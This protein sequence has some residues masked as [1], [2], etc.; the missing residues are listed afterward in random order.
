MTGRFLD[1]INLVVLDK[2]TKMYRV[3][4]G[5]IR[6]DN[7]INYQLLC[8]YPGS[9]SLIDKCKDRSIIVL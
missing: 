4:K 7:L 9:R 5:V 8:E 3:I 6:N 2:L 1:L